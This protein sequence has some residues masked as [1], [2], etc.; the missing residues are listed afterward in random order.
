MAATLAGL[1]LLLPLQLCAGLRA[2]AG[3][4]VNVAHANEVTAQYYW[5]SGRGSV[6]HYSSSLTSEAPFDL[7]KSFKWTWADPVSRY[8]TSP[9]GLNMDD[10]MN[11]YMT[12]LNSIRKFSKDGQVLWVTDTRVEQGE[13][14]ADTSSLYNG[15]LYVSTTH[16]RMYALNMETGKELWMKRL[17]STDG[18]NGFVSAHAGVVITGSDVS[19]VVRGKK[20]E[21]T[22]ARFSDHKVTGLSA[23]DGTLLWQFEPEVPV[24]SFHASFP[25]DGTFVFQDFEGRVYRN[26]LIDGMLMWKAGGVKGSWTNGAALLGPNGVVYAVNTRAMTSTGGNSPGDVSAYSLNGGQLLWRTEVP[27]PPNNMPAVGKLAG[28][29]GL[30]VVQPIG[31]QNVKGAGTEVHALDAQT[32]KLQWVFKGPSQMH[33]FQAGD[34][35][36]H[37]IAERQLITGIRPMVSPNAWSAP[38]IDARGTVY[39]GS[40]EGKIYA[41][42]DEN[43]DGTVSGPA[44]VSSYNAK[45]CFSGSSSPVIAPNLLAVAST[46]ALYVF[47]GPRH[48][49]GLFGK[50]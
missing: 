17:H 10:K 41:L 43:G 20:R 18:N 23:A 14:M 33:K 46:N 22:N 12:S 16:G 42:R 27:R 19:S 32:G 40:E 35:N 11:I 38:S 47:E 28:R 13:E 29:T 31:Q 30:S 3:D 39:I 5:P 7:K 24:W 37:A 2:R 50:K 34:M 1:L 44:E 8:A 36:V 21:G 26:R 6:G 25:N 4:N 15:T 45:A 49:G 48:A 9:V